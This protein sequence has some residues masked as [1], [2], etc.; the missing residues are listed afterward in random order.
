MVVVG[1]YAEIL[2]WD[3]STPP[4]S[5]FDPQALPLFISLRQADVLDLPP[6]A[7][8]SPPAGQ[9]R[10]FDRLAHIVGKMADAKL[11]LDPTWRWPDGWRDRL[12]AVVGLSSPDVPI[13][14]QIAAQGLSGI[15]PDV[16]LLAVPVFKFS[17]KERVTIGHRL[18]FLP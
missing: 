11:R 5:D 15:N 6:V 9:G 7:D 13:A 10:A 17:A 12:C 4:T 8:L 2:P 1:R 3:F 18:P 16:P 14:D